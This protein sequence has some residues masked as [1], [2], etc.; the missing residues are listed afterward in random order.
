MHD[1]LRLP[2]LQTEIHCSIQAEVMLTPSFDTQQNE[3]FVILNIHVPYVKV[4]AAV[5]MI[6][7]WACTNAFRWML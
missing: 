1:R 2:E 7:A 3:E 5:K 4:L 6:Y